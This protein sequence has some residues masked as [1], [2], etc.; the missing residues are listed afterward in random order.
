MAKRYLGANLNQVSYFSSGMAFLNLFKSAGNNPV[1]SPWWT[2]PGTINTAY[3]QMDSDGN[4][5]TLVAAASQ[6][7]F[8]SVFPL[9]NKNICGGILPPNVTSLYPT[10]NYRF[11]FSGPGTMV[12]SG[13]A[14]VPSQT[15]PSGVTITGNTI[16]STLAMGVSASVT[17]NV[18]AA[19]A[20]GIQIAITSLP[21]DGVNYLKYISLVESQYT[22][23]YDAGQ[24]FHPLFLAQLA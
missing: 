6:G 24:L 15:A 16:T 2:N 5:T 21:N 8:T 1:F 12:V 9:V 18:A 3:L 14:T 11:Q 23:I 17:L 10:G 7:T 13:D 22:T 20:N 19:S 4:V